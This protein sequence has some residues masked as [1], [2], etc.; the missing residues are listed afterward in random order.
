MSRY[1]EIQV[2][3]AVARSG[4]L[5]AGAR[6]LEV[7]TATVMRVVAA[8]EAR[9]HGTLLVRGPRGVQL[10]ASGEAFAASCRRILQDIDEAEGSVGGLHAHPAGQ[11]NLSLP[12]LVAD[13]LF[14]PIALDYLAAFPEVRLFSQHRE[15]LPRLLEDGIDVALVIGA[16]P[17]SSGF[18]VPVGTVRPVICASPEY[19]ARHGVPQAPEDLK[20]HRIIAA[21]SQGAVSEWRFRHQGAVRSVRLTPLLACST[22]QAATR[23]ASLGL[24]LTRCMSHEAHAELSDGRLQVVLQDYAAPSLPVQL[25]YREG[26]RAAARVRT[27]LDFTVPRLRAHPALRG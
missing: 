26:R 10:S 14:A 24:G 9:L 25:I 23:A 3:D 15:D 7:S 1:R 4:S 6:Q 18:A 16:L 2:F 11:L 13:Q 19:L 12:L 22:T 5:A 17:D 20:T 27:F 8:L 21:G